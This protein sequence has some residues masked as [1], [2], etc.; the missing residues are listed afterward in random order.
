M[1][2][3]RES[4]LA[5]VGEIWG[6]ERKPW[7]PENP[8]PWIVFVRRKTPA[9][10]KDLV[11]DP[12]TRHSYLEPAFLNDKWREFYKWAR[13]YALGDGSR[14]PLPGLCPVCRGAKKVLKK[15]RDVID[16]PRWDA[17]RKECWKREVAPWS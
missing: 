10:A 5:S 9:S 16:C 3:E 11:A 13:S 15:N 6:K 2:D 17:E 1:S 14:G 8:Q 4:D 12:R 7:P